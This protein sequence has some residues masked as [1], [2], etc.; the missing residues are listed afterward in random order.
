MMR[1]FKF[2]LAA[3]ICPVLL[4]SCSDDEAEKKIDVTFNAIPKVAGALDVSALAGTPVQFTEVRNQD[5]KS[6]SLDANGSVIASLPMGVYNV[7]IEKN[8]TNAQGE[9]VV[10][11]LRMENVNVNT[12]GQVIDGYVNSLPA[13]ALGKDFI[14]SE[15]FFNGETNS[16]RMMHPDQYIVLFNPTE[17]VLYADGVSVGVTMHISWWPKELWYDSYYPDQV[18]IG[19]FITIPGSGKEHPVQPGEKLVIAFTAINH[20][21]VVNGEIA[22]DHAVDL[23]GADFEVY[24]GPDANDVDN[25][26]V[27]NVLITENGDSYGFF[28]QPRGYVSPVMFRLENGQQS[29]VDAFVNSHT[30]LSKTHVDATETTPEGDI[31]IHI[32]AIETENIIDGIQ[33]SDVPQDVKTR[34]VPETVDRGKFLVNGCHRQELCIRKE[35]KVGDK[36]FYQDTNNSSEDMQDVNE[37][38]AAGKVQTA[39]P[40]GWRNNK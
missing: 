37:R 16:G 26:S 21:E 34:V 11:S 29:T 27:P 28:F 17:D 15:V 5:T 18:P 1:L 24:Y 7:S 3:L 23:S 40:V 20:S 10:I 14:F 33:T 31:D 19:G 13:S 2:A 38:K 32:L 4:A 25:P 9:Q 35:I 8:I 39:F 12:D 6:F 30:T 22:Y 36:T